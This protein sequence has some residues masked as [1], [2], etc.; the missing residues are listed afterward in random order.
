M[1]IGVCTTDFETLPLETLFG[2]IERLGFTS[3]QLSFDTIEEC[4]FQADG[5]FEIPWSVPAEITRQIQFSADRHGLRILC[6]NGTFNMAHPDAAARDEGVKR[7]QGF[8]E[9]VKALGCPCISL[10]TGTR[11]T[12]YLWRPHP[13]NQTEAAWA[14]MEASMRPLIRIAESLDLT[15]L[16]ETEASNVLDTPEKAR[17]LMDD[18]GS[19]RLK[20]ILDAANLFHA[21][22][23]HPEKV[24]PTIRRAFDAFGGDIALAHGKDIRAGD[25]ID[26]CAAGEGI[27]DFDFMLALLKDVNYRGDMVLHGIHGEAGMVPAREFMRRKILSN[28]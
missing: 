19:H 1:E 21:G 13:D 27:V 17:R 15:L 11:N 6:V 7:F 26:F 24:R 12:D 16:L 20:M 3:V 14:D 10:C 28:T 23:A 22:D 8:A 25:G 2:K 4:D 5:V 18:M 9:A